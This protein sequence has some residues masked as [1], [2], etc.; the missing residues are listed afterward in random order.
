MNRLGLKIGCLVV[1]IVIWVQVAATSTVE[2]GTALPL[3]VV[4]L[5]Q[6]L[7]L[8]GSVVPQ[9][10]DVTLRMT[11]LQLLTHNYFNRYVGE[12]RINLADR[13]PGP[14][15]SYELTASDV[16][17]DQ[18][19]VD[20]AGRVRLHI[21]SLRSRIVPIEMVTEGSLPPDRAFVE[22]LRIQPD[23][24]SVSGAERFFPDELTVRTQPI[25]L[26]SFSDSGELDVPLVAPHRELKLAVTSVRALAN[27]GILEDR[28]L[29]NIPVVPLVDAG[30][31]EVGVSPP[32]ADV[33]VRGVADSVRALTE[34]R[35]TITVPVGDR[36]EGLYELAGQV[37]HPDWLTYVRLNPP[38]FQVIVGS[39]I[40]P[41]S[42]PADSTGQEDVGD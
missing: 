25:S 5:G 17:S 20:I 38:V 29:A 31:P 33:M 10:V 22:P 21:D 35:F 7:T 40:V 4:G 42:A 14:A 32:V 26:Q 9:H 27:V 19:V 34:S 8:Q 15:F 24:V 3:R 37:G 16:F 12:V 6:G 23:S 30:L 36:P 11:K 13:Q 41:G 18:P 1:S 28:T 39:P 2:R